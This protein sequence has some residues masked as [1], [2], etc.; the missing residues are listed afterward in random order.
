[1]WVIVFCAIEK[2]A[3]TSLEKKKKKASLYKEG[4][5]TLSLEFTDCWCQSLRLKSE[6]NGQQVDKSSR[7]RLRPV[8]KHP[9]A[10]WSKATELTCTWVTLLPPYYQTLSD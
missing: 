7:P 1:M 4:Q 8:G 10:Q 3:T 5:G 6:G 9:H 2:S